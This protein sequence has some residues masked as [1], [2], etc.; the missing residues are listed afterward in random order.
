MLWRPPE[1]DLPS[2]VALVELFQDM[3]IRRR[4]VP[5][6]ALAAYRLVAVFFV[7][8]TIANAVR[9]SRQTPN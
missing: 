8:E 7:A 2:P 1:Y 4:L 5:V 6:D 9:C 3:V